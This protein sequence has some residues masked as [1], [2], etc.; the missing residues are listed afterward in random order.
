M[1]MYPWRWA[2]EGFFLGKG[3]MLIFQGQWCKRRGA[4]GEKP[5]P[6]VLMFWNPGKIPENTGKNGV[7]RCL[8]SENNAQRLQKST[9][10][11]DN[12]RSHQKGFFMG[13]HL[14]AKVTQNFLGKFGRLRAKICMPKNLPGPTLMFSGWPKIFLQR[15][16]KNGKISF[17]LLVTK[18]T[19]FLQKIWWENVKFQNLGGLCPSLRRPCP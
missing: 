11:L 15:G 16:P 2:L 9:W 13:E 8:T 7:L 1:S 18:K 5:P 19:T 3:Q 17:S 4:G 14:L 12:W 10:I 6:K